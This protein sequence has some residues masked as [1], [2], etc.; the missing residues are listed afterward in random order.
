[1]AILISVVSLK[2]SAANVLRALQVLLDYL[3]NDPDV[4]AKFRPSMPLIRKMKLDNYVIE[5]TRQDALHEKTL[6]FLSFLLRYHRELDHTDCSTNPQVLQKLK[7]YEDFKCWHELE[8]LAIQQEELVRK[9]QGQQENILSGDSQKGREIKAL[10]AES[11]VPKD[12]FLNEMK[13]LQ[14]MMFK[15]IDIKVANADVGGSRAPERPSSRL[16]NE[17]M[18]NNAQ[19]KKILELMLDL[20]KKMD[21]RFLEAHHETA[22]AIVNALDVS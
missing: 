22:N 17:L 18:M 13:T 16:K 1:M 7:R 15:E 10:V 3:R 4:F 9:V 11:F 12:I 2:L 6:E 21:K 20:E 19:Y 8:E 14:D 5:M